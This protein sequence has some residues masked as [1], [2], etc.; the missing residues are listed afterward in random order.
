M[1]IGRIDL[2][3]NSKLHIFLKLISKKSFVK[4]TPLLVIVGVLFLYIFTSVLVPYASGPDAGAHMVNTY[5]AFGTKKDMCEVKD[6]QKQVVF[7]EVNVPTGTHGYGACF[8]GSTEIGASCAEPFRSEGINSISF[9]AQDFISSN[10]EVLFVQ[11]VG[12]DIY[13]G[14]LFGNDTDVHLRIFL[15]H[16][17]I[18]PNIELNK[19]DLGCTWP[20]TNYQET[21]QDSI[22]SQSLTLT[23]I[24]QL[25]T[26]SIQLFLNGERIYISDNRFK[27]YTS[28]SLGP[29][30]FSNLAKKVDNKSLRIIWEDKFKVFSTA[31]MVDNYNPPIIYKLYNSLIKSNVGKSYQT[32]KIVLISLLAGSILILYSLFGGSKSFYVFICSLLVSSVVYGYYIFGTNNTS[33]L[34]YLGTLLISI[35][36]AYFNQNVSKNTISNLRFIILLL[37]SIILA[38]GRTDGLIF[39]LVGY[40]LFSAI[41]LP[42]KENY[43]SWLLT[44]ITILVSGTY[45]YKRYEVAVDLHAS[46][47]PIDSLLQV[48]FHNSLEIIG[49]IF[50]LQG[51]R[52]PLGIWGFS[53]T[54][55]LPMIVFL[56]N[57]SA[58]I[59][60]LGFV[61]VLSNFYQRIV[62]L[63]SFVAIYLVFASTLSSVPEAPSAGGWMLPRYGLSLYGIFILILIQLFSDNL[64]KFNLNIKQLKTVV[65]TISLFFA[66]GLSIA[67]YFLAAKN[68]NGLMIDYN[69]SFL[70]AISGLGPWIPQEVVKFRLIDETYG[71]KPYISL[72]INS[73]IV[74]IFIL[75]YMTLNCSLKKAL[76]NRV[77]V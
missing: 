52:G 59:L 28:A 10:N 6:E 4:L 41:K 64:F 70:P 16:K 58:F 8:I 75:F 15:N 37:L 51:S 30:V 36:P 17:V 25:S 23:F 39:A 43:L 34:S 14:R 38:S 46:K 13:S 3:N 68:M 71:W 11:R 50:G 61:I 67:F 49:V 69:D 54:E 42:R 73:I 1:N 55:M 72:P 65:R 26:R 9:K 40:T 29:F 21:T 5:C 31:Y 20:C 77:F 24:P 35:L 47:S 2:R 60:I 45:L 22:E 57:F 76:N 74:M 62:L 12:R 33:N 44:F 19:I 27:P 32:I 18:S 7:R 66:S 53:L 56:L 48:T 63:T